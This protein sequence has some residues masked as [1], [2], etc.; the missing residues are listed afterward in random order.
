MASSEGFTQCQV[1]PSFSN[2]VGSRFEE[3][4]KNH[5]KHDQFSV[6]LQSIVT[7]NGRLALLNGVTTKVQGCS[8]S[9][10]VCNKIITKSTASSLLRGAHSDSKPV[11]TSRAESSCNGV[12]PFKLKRKGKTVPKPKP[13]TPI[14]FARDLHVSILCNIK[15]SPLLAEL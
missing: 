11:I 7:G 8:R 1:I 4:D 2:T 5:S 14:T 15:Y 10:T 13:I 6:D 12:A 3:N 9:D